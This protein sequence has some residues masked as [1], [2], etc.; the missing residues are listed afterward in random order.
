MSQRAFGLWLASGAVSSSMLTS[1]CQ[2]YGGLRA[3]YGNVIT[4]GVKRLR[5]AEVLLQPKTDESPD[6]EIIVV[7]VETFP[8]CGSI[9]GG[10]ARALQVHLHS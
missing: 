10:D 8:L 9:F 5:C 1:C 2:V 6:N 4:V 3:H 7:G